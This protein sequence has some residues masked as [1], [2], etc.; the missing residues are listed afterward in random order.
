MGMRHTNLILAAMLGLGAMV[1]SAQAEVSRVVVA[2]TSNVP[3]YLKEMD[4]VRALLKRSGSDA[5]VRVWRARFA[6]PN[7]GMLVVTIEYADMATFAADDAKMRADA[8]YDGLIKG[9]DAI[10]TIES[11][12]LYEEL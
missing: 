10:R 11:D 4:K 6:G 8:E 7:A 5:S 2:K 1:G 12:S 3:A 9:L